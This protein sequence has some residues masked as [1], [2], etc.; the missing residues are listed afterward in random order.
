LS[1]I[2]NALEEEAHIPLATLLI[3][4]R[5]SIYNAL[6]VEANIPLEPLLNSMMDPNQHALESES[7]AIHNVLDEEKGPHSR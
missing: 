1:P 5:N 2:Q 6:V 4:I 3:S 7:S